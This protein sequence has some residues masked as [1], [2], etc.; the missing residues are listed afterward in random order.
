MSVHDKGEPDPKPVPAQMQTFWFRATDGT[1]MLMFA[2]PVGN[3]DIVRFTCMGPDL[4]Q[5]YLKL[6]DFMEGKGRR[7][8]YLG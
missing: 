4:E 6:R 8:A 7:P 5:F 2:L 1:P 3:G